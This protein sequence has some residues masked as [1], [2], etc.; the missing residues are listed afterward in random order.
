[1]TA[2]TAGP[3]LVYVIAGEESGDRLGAPMMAAMIAET[4]GNIAFAGIGGPKM[5]ALGLSSLFPMQD[6]AVMGLT[7][8]LPRL[9]RLLKRIG[10]VTDDTRRRRPDVLVTID[11]P[12]FSFRVAR[13]LKGQGVTLV[14]YVAPSVWAWRPGRARKI[15]GFL[16]HLMALLPFEP[17]YFEEHGL[18]CTYVGHPVLMSG[19]ELGDGQ[20]FRARRAIAAGRP[21]LAVLPGSRAGECRR[22][23]AVFA[24]VVDLLADRLPDLEIVVP[25]VEATRNLVKT[26]TQAWSRPVHIVD[27][28][29]AKYDSFAAAD[30]ALA[31]SGTVALE[32]AMAGTP[33]V[34]AYRMAPLTGFLARRLVTA[35]YA[36]LV[37]LLL[38]REAVPEFLL[39]QCRP[40]AIAPALLALFETP[41]AQRAQHSAYR[42]ALAVLGHGKIDPSKK[43]A[44]TVLG[45][46]RAR[47]NGAG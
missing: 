16:D 14:H 35:P 15:A 26:A 36:N 4:G 11:A 9:P 21:L 22:L 6:L 25:T 45:L 37:N 1:M 39:E 29:T 27:T 40:A 20:A 32:L 30:A 19:A 31:A 38:G 44:E 17:P 24:E 5:T 28:D 10:Q 18:P 8:V 13:K 12:D 23:L 46:I 33:A 42:E 43:A 7:E 3:P 2:P 34:I 41:D 47:Q